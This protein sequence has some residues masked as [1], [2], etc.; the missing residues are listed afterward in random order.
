MPPRLIY[1]MFNN[2]HEKS[3]QNINRD[4]YIDIISTTLIIV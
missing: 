3:V 4:L 2:Q 1:D